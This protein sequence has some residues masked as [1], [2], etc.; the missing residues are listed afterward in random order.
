MVAWVG[1]VHF[2]YRIVLQN[3]ILE[4]KAGRQKPFS[5]KNTKLHF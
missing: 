4:L 2:K 3:A 1:H 5:Q